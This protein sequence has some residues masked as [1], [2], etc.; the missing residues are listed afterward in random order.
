MTS[1]VS[2]AASVVIPSHNPHLGRLREALHG[3]RIQSLAPEL[4]E[5]LLIDNASG[6]FPAAADYGDSA[7]S[8]LRVLR[9]ARLGLTS[10]RLTGIRAAQGAIIVFVDDDNILAPDYIAEAA[11][12]FARDGRL[13]AVGGKSLAVFESTP[14]PWQ[15]EFLPLLA[16]R[17]LGETEL[18]AKSLRPAGSAQKQYP[19]CAPIGAGMALRREAA[20][21]WAKEVER[22]PNRRGLDRAGLDLASGG[23]N[24]IVMT[25][26]EHGWSVGYFPSL[27][28]NH[29]IPSARLGTRYLARLNRAIQCSWIRVLS[30]HDACPW[31]PIAKWT[32]APRQLKAWFTRRAWRGPAA[33]IRWQGACGHFAGRAGRSP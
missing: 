4:W 11:R 25:I 19:L 28:L 12:L 14:A 26:L 15:R 7:P 6:A 3:L 9:E 2:T 32:V 16:V 10:A 33:H 1:P 24:D 17:D 30:A 5:T 18:L 29:M 22:D 13:G 21:A 20:L 31:G 8:N 27:S 23:D